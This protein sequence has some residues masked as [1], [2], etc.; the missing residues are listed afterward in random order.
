MESSNNNNSP[1]SGQQNNKLFNK[2]NFSGPSKKNMAIAN[3]RAPG[4]GF[5]KSGADMA[6]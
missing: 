1:G 4:A 6:M 3:E 5:K 2:S